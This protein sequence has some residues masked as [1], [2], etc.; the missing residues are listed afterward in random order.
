MDL[1]TWTWGLEVGSFDLGAWTWGLGLED[2]T[3]G[4]GVGSLELGT[5]TWGSGLGSLDLGTGSLDLGTW[6]WKLG[7]GAN[8]KTQ[9]QI[10]HFL[11]KKEESGQV[12][13]L[14]PYGE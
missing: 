1:G 12:Q 13:L 6:T 3:W 2:W 10:C 5:W 7:L 14:A 9:I 11:V 4:L 8:K